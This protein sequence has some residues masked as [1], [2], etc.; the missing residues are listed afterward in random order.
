MAVAALV[1]VSFGVADSGAALIQPWVLVSGLAVVLLSPV[2]LYHE[3]QVSSGRPAG[4]NEAAQ[5]PC[6]APHGGAE[7]ILPQL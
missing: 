4:D 5:P 6:G 7:L 3:E 1:A 2:I